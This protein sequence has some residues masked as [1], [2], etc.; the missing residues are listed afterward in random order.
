MSNTIHVSVARM[1]DKIK[2]IM[3][4]ILRT[5]SPEN[6]QPWKIIV[7]DNVVEIFHLSER[8]KLGRLHDYMSLVG[9]GMVAEGLNLACSAEGLQSR[10]TCFLEN[11][12]D[13]SPWLRAEL[14]DTQMPADPLVK[15]LLLRHTDRRRY[16]G[17]SLNDPVFQDLRQEVKEI[18]GVNLYFTDKY[19]EEY[20]RLLQNANQIIM[21]WGELRQDFNKWTR[22]TDKEIWQNRDGMN[23]RSFLRGPENLIYYL[24]SRIWWLAVRLDCFPAWLMR[25]ETLFFDDSGDLSPSSYDDGAG[26][27]CIATKSWNAEDLV[28]SG[29]LALRI[30]LLLNLRGYGFQPLCNLASPVYSERIGQPYLPRDLVPLLAGGYETLQCMFGFP[31]HEVPFFYFRTGLATGK[32]P[33]NTMSLRRIEHIR[34]DNT[35]KIHS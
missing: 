31:D 6:C 34:I 32:Y 1:N 20:L 9:L 25:L 18:E 2:R 30:W 14:S 3:Q 4:A 10:I 24:R 28:A 35:T 16:A 13:N 17:G 33:D 8:A 11:R 23:W 5:P 15:G 29:R 27:G 19:P 7:R 26:I 21:R 12:S 22:F